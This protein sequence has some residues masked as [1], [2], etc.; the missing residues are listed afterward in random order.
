VVDVGQSEALAV[1]LDLLCKAR[2]SE[3]GVLLVEGE[4]G[5][6]KTTVLR[7]CHDATS[8]LTAVAVRWAEPETGVPYVG[9]LSLCQPLLH[10]VHAVT[11]HER[12]TLMVALGRQEGPSTSP[13]TVG[14]AL[15]QLVAAAA[16]QQPL[17]ITIDDLQWFAQPSRV[18]VGRSSGVY[19]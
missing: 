12:R 6:G 3:A 11:A 9:V 4:A 14:A 1:G 5:V 10:H 18:A 15:I 8:D 2:R 7:Q 19:R 13:A 17:L 16:V